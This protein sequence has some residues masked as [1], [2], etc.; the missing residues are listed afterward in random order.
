MIRIRRHFLKP[1]LHGKYLL[2]VKHD[3]LCGVDKGLDLEF[4]HG[5]LVRYD[6][7][8]PIGEPLLIIS[9]SFADFK[10]CSVRC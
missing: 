1:S 8:W 4:T 7:V 2:D 6:W 3:S 10:R 9:E 5:L